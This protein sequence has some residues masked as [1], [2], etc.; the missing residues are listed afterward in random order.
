MAPH[1]SSGTRRG[2]RC[3]RRWRE[4]W[5]ARAAFATDTA[6]GNSGCPEE[7]LK[8]RWMRI[9][10]DAAVESAPKSAAASSTALRRRQWWSSRRCT[11]AGAARRHADASALLNGPKTHLLRH[12]MCRLRGPWSCRRR[13]LRA[14][15]GPLCVPRSVLGHLYRCRRRS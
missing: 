3:I 12:A 2:S 7:S 10:A 9:S 4:L 5:Q 11:T 15:R 13:S 8:G 6:Q 1:A 14:G